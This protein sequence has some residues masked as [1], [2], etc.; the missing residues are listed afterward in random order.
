MLL[1]VQGASFCPSFFHDWVFQ[2][3]LVRVAFDFLFVSF[4]VL[5]FPRIVVLF[6]IFLSAVCG[7]N[8][9][10]YAR[11]FHETMSILSLFNNFQEG[12]AATSAIVALIPLGT[13]FL[14]LAIVILCGVFLFLTGRSSFS[15]RFRL[16]GSGFCLLVYIAQMVV[17]TSFNDLAFRNL[18]SY[19]ETGDLTI[20]YGYTPVWTAEFFLKSE[21]FICQEALKQPQ[22]DRLTPL[23]TPLKIPRQIVAVQVE[24]LD[25]TILDR[26]FNGKVVTPFLNDL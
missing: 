15:F 20:I 5:A 16:A 2:K 7:V 9:I 12:V 14:F 23:E 21:S 3:F 4:F 19:K 17:F 18:I 13:F 25:F 26:E 11:T 8:L 24:S 10:I 22:T 1:Y 6:L